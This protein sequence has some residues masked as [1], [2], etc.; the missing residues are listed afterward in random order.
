[1]L[2]AK[3]LLPGKP[4]L[5]NKEDGFK[6]QKLLTS[7]SFPIQSQKSQTLCLWTP[8]SLTHTYTYNYRYGAIY[9]PAEGRKQRDGVWGSSREVHVYLHP[10]LSLLPSVFVCEICF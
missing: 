4:Y 3:T 6:E 8:L 7:I 10:A 1:M 5:T 9:M 2:Q